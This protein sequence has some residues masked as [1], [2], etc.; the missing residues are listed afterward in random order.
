MDEF[1]RPIDKII[2]EAREKGDFENLPG[3]GKPIRW[4]DESMVPEDQR[5]ANRLLKNNGFTLDWIELGREI[6]REYEGIRR[7]IEQAR[8]DR[9]A[10]KLDAAGWKTL[11]RDLTGQIRELNRRIIGYNL[12]TPHEQVQKRPYPIDPDLLEEG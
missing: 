10:G 6:E 4:E 2:R 7:R 9:A 8:A 1:E 11:A 5:M 12:R 3:K